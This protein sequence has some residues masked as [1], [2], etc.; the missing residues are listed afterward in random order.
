MANP[1]APSVVH[2]DPNETGVYEI[3]SLCMN[4]RDEGLTRILPIKIPF[5]KEI[6]LESFSCDHCG[7]KNNTVKSAGEIQEKGAKF[8]F[9]LDTMDDFQRQ[10]VRSDTGIFRIEDIGLEMPPAPGQFTNL[11]G[12]ISKI[13]TDLENDQPARK[14]ASL[15]LYNALQVIIEKLE[16]MLD[17]SGFP[18]TV[19]LDDISGNSFIEPSTDDKGSKYV[20]TDYLRS[21]QQ[22]VQLGL[23]VDDDDNTNGDVMEGVDVVDNEVYELHA[24]CP[25]CGKPCTVNM[26]KTNIPHFKEV[27]I[28]A[29]V[30]EH[31]GFRTSDVKTGGA[32]PAKGKRITLEVKTSEDLSRDVLKS[33]SCVLKS[34]DLGLE[35]QPGTLGG[36]FTTLEGL[37]SQ[38]RDQLHG[39]IYNVGDEDLTGGDSMT[40]D[41]KSKWD[42]FFDKLDSAIKAEFPYSITLEDPLANSFVQ[43]NVD[44]GEDPQVKTEEYERTEEEMEDLGLNDMKTE[45]YEHDD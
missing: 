4:C 44:S 3:Q 21:H 39:Q 11:E 18:F 8:T 6:L 36:R 7:W 32:V 26:K 37:L 19:S 14:E 9:R 43:L 16:K 40:A 31:C 24:E 5:F 17:G 27:I 45:N 25:A 30:C 13:K 41:T 20:R 28:M 15:E 2:A 38:V 1:E 35:V 34:H 12:L 10:I 29:T 22:N 42:S 23:V 33:E